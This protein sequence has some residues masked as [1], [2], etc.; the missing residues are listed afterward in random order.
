MSSFICDICKRDFKSEKGCRTHCTIMHPSQI[1]TLPKKPFCCAKCD[2]S[3]DHAT[4]LIRHNIEHKIEEE[5]A[6]QQ[7]NNRV[8][9]PSQLQKLLEKVVN[10]GVHVRVCN[11]I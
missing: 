5:E 10:L 7:L 2:K 8:Q 11:L 9:D 4:T 6:R 3:F 1:K